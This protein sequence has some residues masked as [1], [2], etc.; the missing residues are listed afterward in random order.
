MDV[1]TRQDG[2]QLITG[3]IVNPNGR[4]SRSARRLQNKS[5]RGSR[6]SHRVKKL[7]VVYEHHVIHH[8]LHAFYGLCNR[9]RNR[10]SIRDGIRFCA[11]NAS[12]SPPTLDHGRRSTGA[13]T[14]DFRF[15]RVLFYPGPD[16]G[17]E[18]SIA[19]RQR[20]RV[21]VPSAKQFDSDRAGA[22]T[23]SRIRSVLDKHESRLFFCFLAGVL[24]RGFEGTSD[25]RH[26]RSQRSHSFNLE[27]I[28]VR[29]SEYLDRDAASAS[30]VGESL[31]EI[32]RRSAD[33]FQLWIERAHEEIGS[34]SFE[35]ADRV[36]GLDLHD[37]PPPQRRTELL[38]DELWAVAKNRVD[39]S[40]RLRDVI[41]FEVRGRRPIHGPRDSFLGTTQPT[42]EEV[43]D[44]IQTPKRAPVRAGFAH[45]AN[46]QC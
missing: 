23:D 34:P 8:G 44:R 1:A 17:D 13:D 26:G 46:F 33:H 28:Y 11:R 10:D 22:F 32:S 29:G 45:S 39:C 3:Q 20:D 25:D 12:A 7:S 40:G 30:R 4:Q 41:E 14:D 6:H 16:T 31:P 24:F 19:N 37:R 9:N 18:G 5:Q 36:G 35:A 2:G 38:V 27:G 15:R 42:S 43:Y 21:D